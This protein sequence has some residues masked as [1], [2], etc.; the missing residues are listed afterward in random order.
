LKLFKN[1]DKLEYE[2]YYYNSF[3]SFGNNYRESSF[4]VIVE[5]G[6]YVRLELP[7]TFKRT[8]IDSYTFKEKNGKCRPVWLFRKRMVG[9]KV[10]RSKQFVWLPV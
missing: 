2:L 7:F 5:D 1:H 9:D 4:E 10:V 3:I 8:Y 6:S